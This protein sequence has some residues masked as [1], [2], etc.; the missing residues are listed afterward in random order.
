MSKYKSIPK[1]DMGIK[2]TAEGEEDV[3]EVEDEI[4]VALVPS[5]MHTDDEVQLELVGGEIVASTWVKPKYTISPAVIEQRK[6]AAKAGV[7]A[8]Y[9][10]A[11]RVAFIKAVAEIGLKARKDPRNLSLKY[12]CFHEYLELC[13]ANGQRVGNLQAYS[14]IGLGTSDVLSWARGELGP[15]K[16]AFAEYVRSICAD[17]REMLAQ[18]GKVHPALAIFWQRNFDGLS[19]DDV[20]YRAKDDKLGELRDVDDLKAKY[21]DLIEE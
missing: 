17:Y 10:N 7:V 6:L 3:I 13:E 20:D 15:D 2:F 1:A 19:N 21:K 9:E 12:E 14:A 11:E 8:R 4:S 16:K 5:G 18:D